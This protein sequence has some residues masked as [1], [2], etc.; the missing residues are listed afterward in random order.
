[1]TL[2]AAPFRGG[3]M[4]VIE[5]RDGWLFIGE[6]EGIDALAIYT[7]PAAIPDS[8]Y[9]AWVTT[10]TRRRE[11]FEQAGIT[12][13]S[14]LVPDTCLVYPDKLPADVTM[15]ST[16]PFQRLAALLDDET[17][18]QCV[19]ALDDLVAGRAE[20]DTF[21]STDSH[22]TDWGAYLGYRAAMRHL[23]R[24]VPNLYVLEPDRLEWVYRPSFGALG[25][26]LTP[27]RS[28]TLRMARVV[29]DPTER[30][31]NVHSH[32]RDA[33]S[34]FE[35]DRPDLPTAVIFRDSAMT[36]ASKFFAQSFRRTVFVSSP[37]TVLY[38]LIEREQ[39]DVVIH[40]FGVRRILHAP[41]EPTTSD[42]RGVFGDLL[43]D[44]PKAVADQR[45]A[46][47]LME[48][49][50][51]E[52]ALRASD[53]ALA[54]SAPNARL[55]VFRSRVYAALGETHA[56]LESLRHA[57]V[58]DPS[59]A[60]PH[61]VRGQAMR[62][63][64]RPLEAMAAFERAIELEPRQREYWPMAIIAGI[65]GRAGQASVDVAARAIAR[66][67]DDGQLR[68]AH[69]CAL[70]EVG[71]LEDAE[72]EVRRALELEPET[73]MFRR[74]LASI[75]VRLERW[76]EAEKLLLE[77]DLATPGLEPVT[78]ALAGVQRALAQP[79]PTTDGHGTA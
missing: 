78:L 4:S 76:A 48:G 1:M 32:V 70:T 45:R 31:C 73:E 25:A 11:Y 21:Q 64:E 36:A 62:V 29:D 57:T 47:S 23:A 26:M 60:S 10:L 19:Y 38:D 55:M 49:G 43:L 3:E 59:D 37:N 53:A 58:L 77:V 74:Q 18:A 13:L 41:N 7:D 66:F 12:Y 72:A 30:V 22:W 67:P 61:F 68:Y 6:F 9:Q 65:E 24:E 50:K 8:I 35:Q 42:F 20:H 79:A 33:Y 51:P 5:G 16:T 2:S 46:R 44:D 15:A 71:Q 27:E 56:A 69:G 34:V 54:K 40:E 28:E 17:R 14:F 75:L 52:E 39:P 63:A